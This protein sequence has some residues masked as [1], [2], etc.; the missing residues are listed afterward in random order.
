MFRK[1]VRT[2]LCPSCGRL[3]RAD[4]TECVICG[5]RRPGLWGL[6]SLS[7]RLFRT[8][9]ITQIITAGCIA[10]YVASLV[11]DP[12]AAAWEVLVWVTGPSSPGLSIRTTTFRFVGATWVEVAVALPLCVVGASWPDSCDC[13]AAAAGPA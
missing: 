12:S 7:R 1:E 4:A 11:F 8:G 10:L 2:I 9:S 6:T 5:R 13:P 3:T